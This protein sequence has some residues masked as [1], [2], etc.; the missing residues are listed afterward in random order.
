MKLLL[1]IAYVGTRYGG[2]QVQPNAD[3]VQARLNLAAE[4]LFGYSCDI[5]GCSRTDSGVHAREFC[6]AVTGR[7]SDSLETDIP[8]ARLPLAFSANLPEDICVYDA[9][10]VPSDFHPR[11]GVVMKEYIYRILNRAVRSPFEADRAYHLPRPI[12]E[13]ALEQIFRENRPGD[14][15]P[16]VVTGLAPFGAFCDIGCGASGLLGLRNLCVSRLTHPGDLLRV[17]QRLPV[18]IQSLDPARRRVALTLQELLGT[19]EENA[20]RFRPGQSVPGVVCGKT[21]YGVF[22]ALTPNLCG[23]AERDDTLEPGQPV[24]VYIKA[25]HPETLKLK[26]TVLHR[27]DALPPQPLQFTKTQ[28][29]LDVWRYGS[30]EHA[31]NVTV[32]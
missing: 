15:L 1:R 18:L 6:A 8:A 25:I 32:F 19:W 10:F 24:C 17:G 30:R 7:G 23:L 13:A 26:L 14:I 22:I 2:Y 11:Y 29:R 16:A 21:D 27:L 20:A 31:K 4:R 3:T 9:C 28:G 5:V 12:P